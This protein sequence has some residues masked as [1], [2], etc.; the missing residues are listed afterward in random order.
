MRLQFLLSEIVGGLRRNTSM[1]ISVVIVSMVSMFFL[2]AGLLAQRQVDVAKG[3]WYDKVQV[4]VFLCTAQSTGTPSCADGKVTD[5]QRTQI[6]SDLLSLRPLVQE[7]HHESASE[8]YKRFTEQF[9][10]SPELSS[11]DRDAIPESFRIKLSDPQRVGE[12][13]AAIDGAPGVEAVSDQRKVLD[14]FFRLLN[15]V[16]IGA[17]ALAGL[18]TV[19][20]VLLITTT[21]QQ[22]ARTRRRAVEIMRSVGAS[23]LVVRL[24]FLVETVV[25]VLI[26]AGLAIAG[27]WATVRYGTAQFLDDGGGGLVSL[28]GTED[29]WMVAPWLG[30]GGLVVASATAW[31]TLRRHLRV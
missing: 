3:F 27:L 4:S 11:V 24:P 7:V 22:V 2:G 5:A 8:A 21:I 13:I 19:C 23:A 6:R 26:G 16:S 1:I 17:V 30:V 12:I 15:V 29:V 25:A 14:T 9:K 10:N 18:M 20:A 28:I 31:L